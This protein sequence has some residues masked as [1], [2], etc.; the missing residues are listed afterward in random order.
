MADV[1]RDIS[2]N[3]LRVAGDVNIEKV[4][5]FSGSNQSRFSITNQVIGI[6]FYED[7][8]APFLTGSL[9]V[10]DSLDLINNMP[11][12]GQ[13]FIELKIFTPTL[14]VGMGDQ[15]IIQG[16]YYIYKMT[17]REYVGDKSLVYQLHFISEEALNDLNI[18]L[19]RGFQGKISDTVKKLVKEIL[20]TDKTLTIEETKNATRYVSNYWSV[21]RNISFLMDQST[22]TNDSSTYTFFEN[23]DGFNFVSLDWLNEQPV[24]QEFFNGNATQDVKKGGGSAK[25]I[26]QDFSKILELSVPSGFDYIDRIA[27]GTYT[28]RLITHDYTT[29]RYKTVNYDY[30]A[31]F[32]EA[33]ETRLNKYPITTPDV[34]ARVN[35]TIIVDETVNNLFSG[36]GDVSN[37]RQMQDRTS[38]MKQ[39]EAF[40]INIKVKGRTDYT[41]GQ[42][43]KLFI[44]TPSP[45]N[46]NDTPEQT[47]DQMYSGYYLIGAINHVID[48]EKHECYME[49]IKDSLQFDLNTGKA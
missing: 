18:K 42:R 16:R 10:K 8:F 49:L 19:S 6:Q 4:E 31:K 35:A 38:R 29:K 15:G 25:K 26:D 30:L 45:T 39:A 48:K 13:E 27:S 41:V 43:V 20:Q 44:T 37:I 47:V 2:S 22:N 14:D 7:L 9:V 21:V 36:F 34:A 24:I 1:K 28:S 17:E 33:K 11:F 23:R 3:E 12:V 32:N 5:V 40:K 46:A